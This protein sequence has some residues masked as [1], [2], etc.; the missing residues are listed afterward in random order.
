MVTNHKPSFIELIMMVR[1]QYA[2]MCPCSHLNAHFFSWKFVSGIRF[3]FGG[4]VGFL[5][6][7]RRMQDEISN[8]WGICSTA[9]EVFLAAAT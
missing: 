6:E 1:I 8:G 9:E 7:L 3:V 2:Y 5:W 4:E